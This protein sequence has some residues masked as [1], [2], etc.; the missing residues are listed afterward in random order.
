LTLR[1]NPAADG[2]LRIVIGDVTIAVDV[3]QGIASDTV[4]PAF[5]KTGRVQIQVY[6]GDQTTP[7]INIPLTIR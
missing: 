1:I 2:A 6:V 4:L 7:S 3:K 5:D